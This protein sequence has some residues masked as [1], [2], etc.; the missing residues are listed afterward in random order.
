VVLRGRYRALSNYYELLGVERTATAVEIKK[1]YR[2]LSMKYHPDRNPDNPEAEEMFK[3]VSEAYSVLSDPEKKAHYDSPPN[4]FETM[5]GSGFP[6]GGMRRERPDPNGPR[7]GRDLK[8]IARVPLYKVLFGGSHTIRFDYMDAC[9]SCGGTG[10]SK[11]QTCTLCQGKG[12]MSRMEQHGDMRVMSTVPCPKCHG[13]GQEALERCLE[14]GGS[15]NTRLNKEFT[16][17]IPVNLP[18]GNVVTFSGE[19]GVGI[20]G[21]P[22]GALVIRIHVQMPDA[23]KMTKEQREALENFPYGE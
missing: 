9:K 1:A 23:D 2:K 19:G 18:N 3:K 11:L 16:F 12:M 6:F 8:F 21:G 22:P 7:R 14:C 4:M 15:G 10:A 5:F 20:N 17:D 13:T